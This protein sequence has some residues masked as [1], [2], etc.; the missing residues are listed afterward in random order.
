MSKT[1][2]RPLFNTALHNVPAAPSRSGCDCILAQISVHWI[3]AEV[4]RTSLP[5]AKQ[6]CK[7][8]HSFLHI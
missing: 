7:N 1:M 5:V 8:L 3:W 6:E 2:I 4:A